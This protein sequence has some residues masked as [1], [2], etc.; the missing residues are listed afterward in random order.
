MQQLFL[1]DDVP[2]GWAHVGLENGVRKEKVTRKTKQRIR[3][4]GRILFIIY[5]LLL[6]YFL[7]FAESYGR[8]AFF[9]EEYHYNLVPFREILRFWRYRE[10]VG[11]WASFLNLA[12]N[13]IGFMPFGFILP[14]MHRNMRRGW[15]VVP[16]G[17]L[18]SFCVELIQ[19]VFKV[20]CFDVD[21][22]ILNTLGALTGYWAFLICDKIRM[23]HY[24][25]E[26]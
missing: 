15:L 11:F 14:V 8:T 26:I 7:F 22:M 3:W 4:L 24:G 21:D 17:F 13:I 23:I 6:I 10:I 18:L 9:E 5:I 20:G 16:L 12:G 19:L 25:E 1:L 2:G